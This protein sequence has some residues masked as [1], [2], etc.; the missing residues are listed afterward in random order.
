MKLSPMKMI[1]LHNGNEISVTR[2]LVC[3]EIWNENENCHAAAAAAAAVMAA[4][5]AAAAA[6]AALTHLPLIHLY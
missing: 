5:V 3:F 2:I 6:A 1:W 4:A